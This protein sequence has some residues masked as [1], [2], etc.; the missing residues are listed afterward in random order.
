MKELIDSLY[1]ICKVILLNVFAY[2]IGMTKDP[3]CELNLEKNI[4]KYDSKI[5]GNK[6]C[7]C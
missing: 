3:I 5:N 6:K 4:T 2:N 7:L 1:Y